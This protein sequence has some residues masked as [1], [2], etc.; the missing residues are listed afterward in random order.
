MRVGL[1]GGGEEVVLVH[2]EVQAQRVADMAKRMFEYYVLLRGK[3]RCPI[4]PIV[5]FVDDVVWKK[6]VA[7]IY[8]EPFGSIMVNRVQYHQ[9]K[10]KHLDYRKYLKSRNPLVPALMARM[11]YPKRSQVR[12]KADFMRLFGA[13]RL[14][15]ERR[16]LLLEFIE[17]YM[18]LNKGEQREFDRLI[19]DEKPYREVKKMVTVYEK[20]GRQAGLKEGIER[21]NREIAK[22]MLFERVDIDVIAKVTGLSKAAIR[23]L[24]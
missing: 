20:R 4:L 11:N 10:L 5:L 1:K 22:K 9:I 6:P 3:Y 8:E 18:V 7:D 23:K 15:R 12:L 21:R 14:K 19:T 24:A 2:V 16:N 17:T 13:A